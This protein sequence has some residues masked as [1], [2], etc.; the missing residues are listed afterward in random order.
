[1]VIEI[2]GNIIQDLEIAFKVYLGKTLELENVPIS[3]ILPILNNINGFLISKTID[4]KVLGTM[5]DIAYNYVCELTR[6]DKKEY[7][8]DI[9]KQI[10]DMPMGIL[11]YKSPSEC[12]KQTIKAC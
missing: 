9:V 1:M 8:E 7:F 12:L 10:N 4:R 11:K 2:K 6:N 3:I 5:T